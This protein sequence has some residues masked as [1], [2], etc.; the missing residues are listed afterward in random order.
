ML[1]LTCLLVAH[2]VS[3]AVGGNTPNPLGDLKPLPRRSPEMQAFDKAILYLM[4]QQEE[5]G[6]W[7]AEKSGA[8][9]EFRTINGDITLTALA[10]ATML[11]ACSYKQQ[12]PKAMA[13]AKKAM[14]WLTARI[15]A[16]GGIA[17]ETAGGEPV[18]A[19]IFAALTLLQAADLSARQTLHDNAA[20]VCRH[21]ALSMQR[22]DGGFGATPGDPAVRAD[23]TAL[24][25][26]M[27][28]Q[29]R[30]SDVTFGDAPVKGPVEQETLRK[31]ENSIRAGLKALSSDPKNK[32]ILAFS[33]DKLEANWDG[34]M[35]GLLIEAALQIQGAEADA[36]LTYVLGVE[37]SADNQET[38]KSFPGFEQHVKWGE[39]GEGYAA[40]TLL[41]G[42]MMFYNVYGP[43]QLAYNAWSKAVLDLILTHQS[44]DGSWDAAGFDARLGRFWR[45]GLQARILLLLAPPP[46][47]MP[48]PPPDP[49]GP[50]NAGGPDGK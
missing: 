14:Q 40:L 13:A 3:A 27:F 24:A 39:K 15:R 11:D 46:M 36:G 35:D 45:T 17:D 42:S 20:K 47:P 38:I 8:S 34:T 23:L 31:I 12:N 37:Y 5:D 50:N 7:S 19:Q 41:E 49:P 10:A 29:A 44:P 48:P 1:L 26:V 33:S 2:S 43:Q 32:G 28:N 4:S 18:T 30:G 22:K 16:D 25:L 6:H 9:P 21:A